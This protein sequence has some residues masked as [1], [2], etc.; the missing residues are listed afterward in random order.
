MLVLSRRCD[1]EIVI[2]ANIRV[3]VLSVRGGQVRLGISAPP[4][5]SVN[6]KEVHERRR[7]FAA[8]SDQPQEVLL[9]LGAFKDIT[10]TE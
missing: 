7:P 8:V 4:S 9:S 2:G 1:Q 10:A 3:T 6:R 5:I